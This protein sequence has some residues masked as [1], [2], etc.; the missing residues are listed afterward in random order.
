MN[1]AARSAQTP[2]YLGIVFCVSSLQGNLLKIQLA[3]QINSRYNIPANTVK[4]DGMIKLHY[5][6]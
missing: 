1:Y 4:R 6:A 5:S 3:I 2:P